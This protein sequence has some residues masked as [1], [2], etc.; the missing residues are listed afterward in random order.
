MKKIPEYIAGFCIV[1][2]ALIP[3]M[4][5]T[6]YTTVNSAL[7]VWLVLMAGFLGWTLFV[8]SKANVWLKLLLVY[9]YVSCFWSKAPYLSFTAYISVM[10]CFCFYLLCKK[11][12]DY[13]FIFQI[14]QGIF[15]LLVTLIVMQLF[16]KDTLLNFNQPKPVVLGTIGNYMIMGSFITCLSPI[17]LSYKKLNFIPL[18]IIAFIAKSS[19]AVLALLAGLLFYLFFKIKNKAAYILIL[20]IIVSGFGFYLCKDTSIASRL[21]G[22]RWPVWKRTAR[23]ILERPQG[24]GIS[25]YR[26]L[27]PT[28]AQDL[29]SLGK[30]EGGWKYENT[31]GFLVPWR[32]THNCWLHLWFEAGHYGFALFM[33][34]VLSLLWKFYRAEKTEAMLVAAAGLV[35]IGSDMTSHFPTRLENAIPAIIFFLAFY[36][37]LFNKEVKLWPQLA[38][39]LSVISPLLNWVRRG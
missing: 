34:F 9:C 38:Q 12:R 39:R 10:A 29:I 14:V 23:K 18:L 32:R 20:C 26:V 6:L 3:P 22:G 7:W 2:L 17:L 21:D 5:M 36:Q 25:T 24:Y 4:S 31:F 1:S 30:I 27:F 33:G 35:I 8:K 11:I 13:E 16:G 19:G 15:F 28:F 37:S